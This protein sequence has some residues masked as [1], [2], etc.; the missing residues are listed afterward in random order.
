[1]VINVM[2]QNN[3]EFYGPYFDFLVVVNDDSLYEWCGGTRLIKSECFENPDALVIPDC[4]IGLCINVFGEAKTGQFNYWG[5]TIYENEEL[6][7]LYDSLSI[8]LNAFVAMDEL[9]I[10]RLLK[11]IEIM[12]IRKVRKGAP[13]LLSAVKNTIVIAIE[14]ILAYVQQAQ[15]SRKALLVIGI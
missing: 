5:I 6:N 10:L 15:T 11:K 9:T 4:I 13:V 3:V 1:M 2:E 7:A 8:W 12:E 14:D